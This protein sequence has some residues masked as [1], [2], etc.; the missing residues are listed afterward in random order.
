MN[1]IQK[2]YTKAPQ[3]FLWPINR[4]A[5]LY[6]N[7]DTLHFGYC[8]SA[9]FF[10]AC[11]S[12]PSWQITLVNPSPVGPRHDRWPSWHQT[13]TTFG[14]WKRL[15]NNTLG[16]WNNTLGMWYS[17]TGYSETGCCQQSEWQDG[18]FSR[19]GERESRV[20]A[21]GE[22]TGENKRGYL[23]IKITK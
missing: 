17:S 10:L 18:R 21:K 23:D 9:V 5:F 13:T 6:P 16:K 15:K 4:A 22:T 12:C 7:P 20:S 19:I 11:P 8:L 1:F 3:P 2:I 14:I